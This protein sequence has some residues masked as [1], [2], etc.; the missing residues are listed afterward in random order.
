MRSLCAS[1]LLAPSLFLLFASPPSFVEVLAP[2]LPFAIPKGGVPGVNNAAIAGD[3]S[4]AAA[5]MPGAVNPGIV[6]PGIDNPEGVITDDV[7]D[8]NDDDDDALVKIP[9]DASAST[10]NAVGDLAL[11]RRIVVYVGAGDAAPEGLTSAAPAEEASVDAADAGSGEGVVGG[12][13][14]LERR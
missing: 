5:I 2:R 1:P 9:R 14:E 13:R 3:V 10:F 7:D 6:S 12:V 4:P 11:Q 8:D